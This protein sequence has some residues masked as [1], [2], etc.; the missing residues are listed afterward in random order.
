MR[1]QQSVPLPWICIFLKK[2]FW[3]MSV[4]EKWVYK[5]S[6]TRIENL[7]VPKTFIKKSYYY[8]LDMIFMIYL[9]LDLREVYIMS[10]L[11]I[12]HRYVMMFLKKRIKSTFYTCFTIIANIIKDINN[13]TKYTPLK[14]QEADNW[15]N[16][17]QIPSTYKNIFLKY[18]NQICFVG[19]SFMNCTKIY[20]WP[21]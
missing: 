21:L 16:I 11:N 14:K 10:L 15:W 6:T 8:N 5:A 19:V 13:I 7:I 2:I 12:I 4:F 20:G 17:P 9:G 1:L 18:S 3:I